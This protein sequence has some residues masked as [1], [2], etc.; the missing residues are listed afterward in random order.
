MPAKA[1]VIN[2][3]IQLTA[4][5]KAERHLFKCIKAAGMMRAKVS[6]TEA[7]RMGVAKNRALSFS[8]MALHASRM[9]PPM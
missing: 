6:K 3:N 1:T 9:T 5:S 2:T 8:G 7:Q 4:E